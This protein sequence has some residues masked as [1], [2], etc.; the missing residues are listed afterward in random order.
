V[1]PLFRG[2][3]RVP[4]RRS[5]ASGEPRPSDFL[6]QLAGLDEE[7]R[8]QALLDLVRTQ[9]ATVLGYASADEVEAERGFAE[10]GFDSLTAVD[11]RNRLQHATGLVLPV[12]V[13]FDNARPA[14]LGAHLSA[15]LGGPDQHGDSPALSGVDPQDTV[16]H[17]FREA[18]DNGRLEDGVRLLLSVARLRPTFD[19]PSELERP[20]KPVRLAR[21][22][23]H[24]HLLCVPSVVAMAGVHQY[25]RFAAEFREA[26]EVSALPVPG[27]GRGESLPA[28]Q[29]A[30]V[31]LHAD[32]VQQYAVDAPFVLLGSS[33]GGL[34]A[35]A[36]AAELEARGIF[37]SAVVLL[38]SYMM[39]SS[40]VSDF[41]GELMDGIYDREQS[42]S[43]MDRMIR[44][45]PG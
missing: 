35:Y 19:N 7:D 24:P 11:L 31:R 21:G 34:L 23:K 30:L 25:A 9:A 43:A 20:P 12:S 27:F 22:E 2:L 42:Y 40:F 29:E 3:V 38:D 32:M 28:T 16:S 15:E 37:P 18:G 33:S 14:E 1:A 41:R 39:N 17:L 4:A 10:M 36:A 45:P 5:A 6:G 26:N 8:N 44:R 13:I